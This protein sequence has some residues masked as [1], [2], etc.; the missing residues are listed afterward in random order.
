MQK[1]KFS[2]RS[3]L[4][5]RCPS[6]HSGKVMD[7]IFKIRARCP[8]CEHDFHPEPGFYLGALVVAFL[9]TAI[10]T[11]PPMVAMKLMGVSIDVLVVFPLI[12]FIVVGTLL[13][14]YSRI[15]WLHL[16]HWM[17]NRLDSRDD[18]KRS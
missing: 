15:L 17:T 10:L 7:G 1:A 3:V 9:L 16:E 18:G 11:V 8:K 12:E 6:C 5:A 13:F 2:I 14:F 4:L